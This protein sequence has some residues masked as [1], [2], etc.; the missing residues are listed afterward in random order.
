MDYRPSPGCQCLPGL[1]PIPGGHCESS[2][3]LNALAYLGYRVSEADI[4]GG[5]A[6]PSFLFTDSSF[7]FLGGRNRSMREIFLKAAGIAWSRAIPDR[8]GPGWEK[9]EGL[10]GRGLPVPLRVDMRYLPYLYGGKKGPAYMSFG[11]HWVC[12][13]GLDTAR[14]RALV[15]DTGHQEVLGISVKDLEAARFSTTRVWP[16][17]GEYVQLEARQ[18]SWSLDPDALVRSGLGGV[19]ANYDSRGD[20]TE[21]PGAGELEGLQGLCHL[22]GRL[23]H[24]DN[25]VSAYALAPAW[26]YLAGSI[27][28]NGTGGGA[29]RRL[30]ASFLEARAGDCADPGLRDTCGRLAG[31]AGEAAQAWTALSKD[32][33]TA[34]RR[35]GE[36][37]GGPARKAALAEGLAATAAGAENILP[38]EI[39]LRDAIKAW[40]DAPLGPR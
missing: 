26:S 28:R 17:K 24:L 13:V 8:D 39:K 19:L 40:A 11:W 6:G 21:N 30:F 16:P 35:L 10:L 5:G 34:A 20:W 29:F 22:P 7:P 12:L 9:L 1:T 38:I 4:V 14:G 18:E 31:L 23:A 32:L 2:A 15:T 36:A 37:R 25:R 27:E 3:L 33:D